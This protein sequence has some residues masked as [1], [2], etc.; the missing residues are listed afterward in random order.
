MDMS[1]I[2]G[3]LAAVLLIPLAPLS[4]LVAQTFHCSSLEEA[5]PT[6][7]DGRTLR[8]TRD[9]VLT[10][11]TYRSTLYVCSDDITIDGN[12]ATFTGLTA[13]IVEGRRNVRIRGFRLENASIALWRS[14]ACEVTENR[15]EGGS[16]NIAFGTSRSRIAGNM[17]NGQTELILTEES[18]D[19]VVERNTISVTGDRIGI[20]VSATTR[21]NIVRDNIVRNGSLPDVVLST[22]IH[23]SGDSTIV[24]GNRVEGHGVGIWSVSSGNVIAGNQVVGPPRNPNYAAQ[25]GIW[26]A[27]DRTFARDNDVRN[28]P[29]PGILVASVIGGA[30]QRVTITGNTIE[31]NDVGLREQTTLPDS[32]RVYHNNFVDNTTQGEGGF[33]YVFWDN[34]ASCG[35][36]YWS[37]HDTPADGCGDGDGDAICDSPRTSPG[38]GPPYDRHPF[39]APDGWRARPGGAC[40]SPVDVDLIATRVEPIQVIEGGAMVMDKATMVR[41][42]IELVGRDRLDNV[43][44]AIDGS[45]GYHEKS[46][47]LFFRDGVTY[48]AEPDD[49]DRTARL[50]ALAARG[51][52]AWNTLHGGGATSVN[53]S[54]P[55]TPVDTGRMTITATVDP[56]NTIPEHG[57]ANNS[58]D[59]TTKVV[60][61][62]KGRSPLGRPY[63]YVIEFRPA[64]N[65]LGSSHT[66]SMP[67]LRLR[68]EAWANFL[69]A[70]YPVP[71]VRVIF[72]AST[73]TAASVNPFGLLHVPMTLFMG[74]GSFNS[75]FFSVDHTC[76]IM[77]D[78]SMAALVASARGKTNGL[79]GSGSMLEETAGENGLAHE[80][81]HTLGLDHDYDDGDFP[82]G[83]VAA[84]GWDV[85]AL[86]P[87]SAMPRGPKL[88]LDRSN[89]NGGFNYYSVMQR[90]PSQAPW[91]TRSQYLQLMKELTVAVADPTLLVVR[92]LMVNDGRSVLLPAYMTT[93]VVGVDSASS[94]NRLE[95]L[96]SSGTIIASYPCDPHQVVDL[97]GVVGF[98]AGA[99]PWDSTARL[100]RLVVDDRIVD[101]LR[102]SIHPPRITIEAVERIGVD[103]IRLRW[104]AIDDDGD[105]VVAMIAYSHD[106]LVWRLLVADAEPGTV[107]LPVDGLPGGSDCRLRLIATDGVNTVE[108]TSD[109]F[110]APTRPPVVGI[111][112]PDNGGTIEPGS[113]TFLLGFGDDP[114]KGVIA[115]SLLVWRSDRDGELGHGARVVARLSDGAHR[116]V[117]EGEDH[118]GNIAADT[119]R[120]NVA[121]GFSPE[122]GGREEKR[123]R[124]LLRVTPMPAHD[125]ATIAFS[126]AHAATTSIDVMNLRGEV[127]A[128]PW[129]ARSLPP[130]DHAMD[131]DVAS[132]PPGLYLM[133]IA[134]SDGGMSETMIGTIMVSGE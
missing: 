94:R 100:L 22:G 97:G 21:G 99:I 81:G 10:P 122:P 3:C 77:P 126:L 114:E 28:V 118:D 75:Y 2:L 54:G 4:P 63:P 20:N 96:D 133:R 42:W 123:R 18:R 6:P 78:G 33:A 107:I 47:T 15:V 14:T 89:G 110:A 84:E 129:R 125:R 115:D 55:Y 5:T 101:S 34:D 69:L 41:V 66:L 35:G 108:A 90:S 119:I 106:A 117:L 116:I 102:R 39:T 98:I 16:F 56:T 85:L 60:M 104:S 40:P 1:R 59:R 52:F 12:G 73:I 95:T 9:L 36:N 71:D 30:P 11:G 62:T 43:R 7:V 132:L 83:G 29:A 68:A 48:V 87:N 46:V 120:L 25:A 93:G 92:A 53:F 127:V 65:I 103:S 31:G 113:S 88:S 128:V 130:G 79:Y 23:V 26:I 105:V 131:V 70:T 124:E 74:L 51:S 17:F 121:A 44:V 91:V 50:V 61:Y 109:P 64:R 38:G 37:D 8:V 76:Y 112:A 72:T 82:N 67:A 111:M 45:L 19:N 134:V 13:V 57:E 86:T 24:V 49:V 32:L 80:A 58:V 27:R